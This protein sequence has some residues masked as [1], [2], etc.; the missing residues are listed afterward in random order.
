MVACDLWMADFLWGNK[1]TF[2][3]YGWPAGYNLPWRVWVWGNSSTRNQ[4]WGYP[5][6]HIVIMRMGLGSPYPMGIYP[7]PSWAQSKDHRRTVLC[8]TATLPR[9][10][11]S[12]KIMARNVRT[13][14]VFT[15]HANLKNFLFHPSHRIF[16]RMHGALNVGKKI[17]NCIVCL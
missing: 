6:C 9:I 3:G 13:M 7:L 17:I 11:C 1:K 15:F 14:G 16:G 4:I 10:H 8:C 2:G 12:C 5:R